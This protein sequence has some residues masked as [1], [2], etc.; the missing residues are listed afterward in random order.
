MTKTKKETIRI[1]RRASSLT[2]LLIRDSVSKQVHYDFC[3]LILYGS[4]LHTWGP[5]CLKSYI[6]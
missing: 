6:T 2:R 4:K 1:D 3:G 5:L